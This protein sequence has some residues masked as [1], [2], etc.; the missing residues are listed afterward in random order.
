MNGI[1][2]RL[3]RTTKKYDSFQETLDVDQINEKLR[4]YVKELNPTS[5]GLGTHV[6]YFSIDPKTR[7][8]KFRMGGIVR[9]IDPEG[10]YMILSN[11]Q[12]SW[13][14]QIKDSEFYRKMSSDEIINKAKEE[15]RNEARR[16]MS[17][18]NRSSSNKGGPPVEKMM[19]HVKEKN[20]ENEM[21]AKEI[22]RLKKELAITKKRD[23]EIL[24]QIEH[25]QQKKDKY[26]KKY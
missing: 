11:G 8:K 21:L 20:R 2:K 16:E 12:V 18:G 25:D 26:F 10:K 15:G 1:T 13:S 22:E 19:E 6:R 5:I 14:A 23:K 3:S 4:D 9:K 7:E 24:S 17:G